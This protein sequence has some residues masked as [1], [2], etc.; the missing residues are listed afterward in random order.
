MPKKAS[1]INDILIAIS[2]VSIGAILFT[3]NKN[4]F[5]LI[6]NY[7]KKLRVEFI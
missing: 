2:A 5:L 4:D 1:F 6:S 7:L 3:S